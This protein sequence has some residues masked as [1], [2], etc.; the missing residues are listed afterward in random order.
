MQVLH[1]HCNFLFGVTYFF[2]C[3]SNFVIEL[4]SCV[5][6][7]WMTTLTIIYNTLVWQ[8]ILYGEV[9]VLKYVISGMSKSCILIRILNDHRVNIVCI[10]CIIW[11]LEMKCVCGVPSS[12]DTY[13]IDA[14]CVSR[15]HKVSNVY[16]ICTT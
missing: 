11:I 6:L 1:A 16:K 15:L 7:L 14:W 9:C 3:A 12:Y 2:K 8:L 4:L 10:T 13:H 5:I